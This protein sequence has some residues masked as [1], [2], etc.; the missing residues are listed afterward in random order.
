M[1]LF[2]MLAAEGMPR[3]TARTEETWPLTRFCWVVRGMRRSWQF[4]AARAVA[5]YRQMD[6]GK[7]R[8]GCAS[9]RDSST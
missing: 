6:S 3:S 7:S 8:D 2:E 4:V 9:K 1:L 5:P